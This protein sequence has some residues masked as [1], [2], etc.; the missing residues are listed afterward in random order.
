MSGGIFLLSGDD[1]LLPMT[2]QPYG[3]NDVFHALVALAS[4]DWFCETVRA[5]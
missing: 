3:T 5:A 1:E 4:L 2:A